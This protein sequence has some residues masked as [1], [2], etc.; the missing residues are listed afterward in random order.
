[1]TDT[2]AQQQREPE[3]SS[4]LRFSEGM[5]NRIA[6]SIDTGPFTTQ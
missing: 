5:M 2:N 3:K 1:M 4:M 6:S